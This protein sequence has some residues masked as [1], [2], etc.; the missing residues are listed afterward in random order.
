[1]VRI[2]RWSLPSTLVP[3]CSQFVE[4]LGDYLDGKLT[5]FSQAQFYRHCAQCSE[6][7]ILRDT[8]RK[9]LQC[10]KSIDL[11]SV[12]SDVQVRLMQALEKRMAAKRQ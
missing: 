11:C 5:A 8:T 10:Y 3:A 9:T 6:C 7:R 4:D 2:G 1:M 12:P